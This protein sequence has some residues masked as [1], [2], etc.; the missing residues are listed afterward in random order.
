MCC[1]H[2]TDILAPDANLSK[3]LIFHPVEDPSLRIESFAI[4]NVLGVSPK[5]NYY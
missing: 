3:N 4:I 5:L 2:S 1:I